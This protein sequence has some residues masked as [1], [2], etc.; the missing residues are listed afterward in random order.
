MA[1]PPTHAQTQSRL[2][3]HSRSAPTPT[4]AIHTHARAPTR[5][6]PV[7]PHP[8]TQ[9]FGMNREAQVMARWKERQLDW[10]RLQRNISRKHQLDPSKMMM[11]DSNEF[12]EKAEEYQVIQA[13]IPAH[14]RY[15]A[16]YWE[17]SLRGQGARF[18]PV[19]N[20]FR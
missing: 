2:R 3:S 16:S 20:I 5:S 9:Q 17:M 11:S 14:E 6:R 19:G 7:A 4:P 18:V 8:H 10:E 1:H 13:A 12:R 15:G